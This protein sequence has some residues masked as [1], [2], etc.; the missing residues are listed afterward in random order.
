MVVYSDELFVGY[1]YDGILA[2]SFSFEKS[3]ISFLVTY[4]ST[5]GCDLTS[6][7][8]FSSFLTDF[9]RGLAYFFGD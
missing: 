8:G 9:L 7:K 5:F 1:I 2:A 4:L 3:T 6:S